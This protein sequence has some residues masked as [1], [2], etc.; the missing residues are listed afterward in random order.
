MCVGHVMKQIKLTIT[1]NKIR[2]KLFLTKT[3]Q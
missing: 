2:N 3:E 1:L